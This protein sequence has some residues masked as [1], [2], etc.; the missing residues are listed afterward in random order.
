MATT[1]TWRVPDAPS[2]P[3]ISG[4]TQVSA[5]VSWTAPFNGGTTITSY[6]VGYGTSSSAPTT[7]VTATSPKVVT[8]LTPGIKYYFFVRAINV[9]GNGPWSVPSN[10]TMIA[11][12]R[13]NVSG[14]WKQAVPYVKDAGVWKLARPWDKV[15]GIWKETI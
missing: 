3:T 5:T 2:A 6:Q 4:V 15:L 13:V 12:A 14:V 10:A 8:G 7:T 11:G 1:T 9:V